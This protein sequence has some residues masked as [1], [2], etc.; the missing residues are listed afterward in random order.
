MV[1][2]F[3]I[4]WL[5]CI[6]A[7][8]IVP[9]FVPE[10][11]AKIRSG[12]RRIQ[13]VVATAVFFGGVLLIPVPWTEPAGAPL[14]AALVQG[15]IDQRMKWREEEIGPTLELH[16]R[17]AESS[18]ARLIV[19]PE[20]VAPVFLDYLPLDYLLS[21][22]AIGEKNGGDLLFGVP[23]R[24]HE[25]ADMNLYN[26]VISFGHAPMQRYD[27]GHLVIFGEYTPAVFGWVMDLLHMPMSGFTPGSELQQPMRVAGEAVAV[28]ICYE[29]AFGPGVARQLPQA[30]LLVNASNMAWFGHSL[31]ASQHG[32]MSQMRAM[33][34]GRWML[35]ATNTG[36]TAAINERGEIVKALPQFTRGVLEVEAQPRK[37]ATPYVRWANWP[38]LALAAFLLLFLAV[39]VQKP[40]KKPA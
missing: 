17:M 2:G 10:L 16:R 5:I 34:T 35:R 23:V 19:L 40:G 20:T 13:A 26:S 24:N 14:P 29:D 22:K 21:L 15:N 27:K 3:G 38:V 37:G 18:H 8:L 30:T 25:G 12:I 36:L 6:L 7:G 31:A 33:E 28:N 1:G 4:S 39:R 9:D 11:R 32:Q